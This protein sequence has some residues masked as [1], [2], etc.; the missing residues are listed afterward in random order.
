MTA[1][2]ANSYLQ[3]DSSPQQLSRFRV[4]LCGLGPLNTGRVFHILPVLS[5]AFTK[6]SVALFSSRKKPCTLTC[7]STQIHMY[8]RTQVQACPASLKVRTN[9]Q[10][11]V[12]ARF[13]LVPTHLFVAR[14]SLI[15]VAAPKQTSSR[16]S[17]RR[18]QPEFSARSA[19]DRPA[20]SG[21]AS[22][23]SPWT[24]AHATETT[25]LKA[26]RDGTRQ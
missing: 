21:L 23:P 13:G 19:N 12:Q 7:T 24:R 15:T 2:L 25:T 22:H 4:L 16:P 18:R 5:D 17:R 9:R 26:R 10:A 14:P 6:D 11:Y 1:A 8:V 20:E 3:H